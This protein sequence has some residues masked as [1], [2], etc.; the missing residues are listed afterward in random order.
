MHA[1]CMH[2]VRMPARMQKRSSV[3]ITLRVLKGIRGIAKKRK[4]K[5]KE[6]ADRIFWDSLE[7]KRADALF[8]EGEKPDAN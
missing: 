1:P 5:V 6:V 4:L 3:E 7:S 8:A 2:S